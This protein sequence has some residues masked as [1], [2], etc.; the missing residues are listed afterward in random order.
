VNHFSRREIETAQAELKFLAV[1]CERRCAIDH[2]V[3]L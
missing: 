3:W 1:T 2:R